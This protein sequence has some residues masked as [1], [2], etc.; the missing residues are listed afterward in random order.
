MYFVDIGETFPISLYRC[1]YRREWAVLSL[2]VD[3]SHLTQSHTSPKNAGR[4][5]ASEVDP[6][7]RGVL[8][9]QQSAATSPFPP[10]KMIMWVN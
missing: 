10:N 2:D 8:D 5:V 6:Y 1:R 7:A 3:P 4:T 9:F